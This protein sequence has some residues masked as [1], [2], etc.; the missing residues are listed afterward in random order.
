MVK[1][2][3]TSGSRAVLIEAANVLGAFRPDLVLVG[4]WV[5]DLLY[6]QHGHM[7]SIDV[8]L[9]VSPTAGASS[10]YDT[11]R[12]R[13]ADAGYRLETEPTRFYRTIPGLPEE[14][15]LDLITGEYQ[16]GQRVSSVQINELRIS[17]LRGIDL[18]FMA[19]DDISVSGVMP[20]GV[21]NTIHLRVVRPE[22]YI[23][24]KAFALA[25]RTKDKDA[26][27]IAFVLHHFQPDLDTLAKRV[28]SLL[29]NG[30]ARDGYK[31]LKEEFATIESVGPVWAERCIPG[32]GQDVQ[33]ARTAAHED[34]QELFRCVQDT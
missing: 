4:G 32:T 28:Q 15:K 2:D 12:K 20:D 27:D 5:P 24:I 17:G 21:Q 10:A 7:G 34:A 11:I 23:L 33:Q 8:D 31:I 26:Y 22:A 19:A 30:L 1:F 14:V 18:A 3:P 9:A 29:G 6:P 13:L 16:D 25:D